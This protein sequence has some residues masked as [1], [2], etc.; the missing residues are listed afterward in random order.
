MW[1]KQ[2]YNV[3]YLDFIITQDHY[4]LFALWHPLH[5]PKA[6][7]PLLSEGHRWQ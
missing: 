7:P 3:V 6:Q 5:C 2:V 4:S 1:T